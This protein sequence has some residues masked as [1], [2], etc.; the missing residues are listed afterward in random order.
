MK[1]KCLPETEVHEIMERFHRDGY[2]V[3]RNTLSVE[4]WRL[5][6]THRRD[7]RA[8]LR[9]GSEQG[10]VCRA[11]PTRRGYRVYPSVYPRT[12]YLPRAADPRTGMALFRR[13]LPIGSFFHTN[14]FGLAVANLKAVSAAFS[15]CSSVG[16]HSA[17]C[18][19]D[20]N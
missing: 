10:L 16:L 2:A 18:Q 20:G 5:S 8:T 14:P 6:P 12:D 4:E 3:I 19:S 13:Q 7:R 11:R 9:S 17:V 1:S 15:L